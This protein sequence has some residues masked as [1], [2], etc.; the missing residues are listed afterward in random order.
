MTQ[1][2]VVFGVLIF[3]LAVM[4]LYLRL[5]RGVPKAPSD[6]P[7]PLRFLAGL[8]HVVLYAA[9]LIMPVSGAIAWFGGVEAAGNAH[10]TAKFLLIG[11]VALHVVGALYQK[12]V[13]KSEATERMLR[14]ER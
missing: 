13:L 12:F 5:A 3:V 2:H 4:R 9:I 10:S 1:S 7:M 8:T 6:E 11:F 14:P